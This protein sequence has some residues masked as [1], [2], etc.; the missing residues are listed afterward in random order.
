MGEARVA[1]IDRRDVLGAGLGI[2]LVNAVGAAP[3]LFVE[4][5]TGWYD[6]PALTPPDLAFPIVW[7]TLFTLM[8]VALF[9][10]WRTGRETP[11]GR[12]ALGLFGLQ[13]ALNVTWTPVFFGLRAPLLGFAVIL[14]LWVAILA[15]IVAADRVDRRAAVLLVP[16]LAWVTLAAYLNGAIAVG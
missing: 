12:L 13:L 1:R 4:V 15:T 10:L 14:A 11:A 6:E 7:T 2:V 3:A 16:Y 8:G 9:L 5:D